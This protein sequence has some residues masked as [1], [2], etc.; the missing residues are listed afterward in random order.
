MTIFILKDLI[1]SEMIAYICAMSCWN[2][3]KVCFP[4][5]DTDYIIKKIAHP[6]SRDT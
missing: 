6:D 1:A 3:W 5:K 4:S 2:L